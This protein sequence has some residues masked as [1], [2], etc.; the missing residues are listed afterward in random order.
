[1]QK[2]V[3]LYRGKQG[4]CTVLLA[5]TATNTFLNRYFAFEVPKHSNCMSVFALSII[6]EKNAEASVFQQL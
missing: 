1:M 6:R 2:V 4:T 5:S 3:D